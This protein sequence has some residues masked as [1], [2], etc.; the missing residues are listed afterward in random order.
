V[1]VAIA[2]ATMA[3]LRV[4]MRWKLKSTAV[5]NWSTRKPAYMK[6]ETPSAL[7]QRRSLT[8]WGRNTSALTI[9][10]ILGTSSERERRPDHRLSP[11]ALGER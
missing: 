11:A 9:P 1:E 2:L 5:T 7:R 4:Q 10:P 8:T 6:T 3:A